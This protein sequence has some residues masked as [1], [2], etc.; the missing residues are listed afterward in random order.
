[1]LS[2]AGTLKI[3]VDG[4]NNWLKEIEAAAQP[5][6]ICGDFDSIQPGLI[7]HYRKRGVQVVETPDQDDTDFGKAVTIALDARKSSS[8]YAFESIV[9]IASLGG[10]IDHLLSSINT[11]YRN[12]ADVPIYLYDIEESLSWVLASVSIR[13][14]SRACMTN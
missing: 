6:I 11:L 14:H 9:A 5:D 2:N 4:G 12:V 3:G 1:M 8:R 13:K 7:D 10:R